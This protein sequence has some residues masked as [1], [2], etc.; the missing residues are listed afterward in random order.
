MTDG[1]S[2]IRPVDPA[3]LGIEEN[4]VEVDT[5]V[6]HPARVYDWLLGGKDN[7]ASD[8]AVGE[9]L[10]V[11]APDVQHLALRNREFI[12]RA[13][14]YLV[15][16]EGIEQILDVGTGIP[17]VPAVHEVAQQINPHVRVVYV[18]NDP[19]VLSHGRALLSR[20]D[21]VR[22]LQGDLLDPGSVLDRPELRALIDFTQPVAVLFAAVFHFV[23]DEQ[24]PR[25]II[26]AYRDALVPGSAVVVSHISSSRHERD[27]VDSLVTSYR[28][29]APL[30]FRSDSEVLHLFD[31]FDLVEPGLVPLH[32]WRPDSSSPPS[33][34]GL[35]GTA[36]VGLYSTSAS[37]S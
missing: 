2:Y 33:E 14:R 13:V 9:R 35:W 16:D 32:D 19:V 7:F 6:A 18:D 12:H 15:R 26:T 37:R 3:S 28:T 10:V 21:G 29:S 11:A 25:R 34:G 17:T 4:H 23:T 22:T 24:D 30:V 31:G 27:E 5:S 1:R 8:R 20:H 36:G